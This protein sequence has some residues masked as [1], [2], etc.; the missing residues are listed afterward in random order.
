MY[1]C[2]MKAYFFNYSH[3]LCMANHS[4]FYL[5]PRQVLEMEGCLMPLAAWVASPGDWVVTWGDGSGFQ[6]VCRTFYREMCPGVQFCSI[7]ECPSDVEWVPWGI[8]ALL[9]ERLRKV[10]MESVFTWKMVED[11]RRLSS[12]QI[13]AQVLRHLKQA[14]GEYKLCG[15]SFAITDE[16][17]LRDLL[18]TL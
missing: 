8:D 4:R 6:D 15:D 12:R 2:T 14:C 5:P 16:Q 7:Q 13:A 9:W 1:L 11:V 17:E 10:G 3:D 18:W